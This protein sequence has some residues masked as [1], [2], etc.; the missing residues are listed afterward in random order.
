MNGVAALRRIFGGVAVWLFMAAASATAG[1]WTGWRGPRGDG[2]CDEPDAPERWSA[3]EQVRWKAD[4]PGKGVSSPIIAGDRVFLTA[5][6]GPRH[7]QLHVLCLDARDGHLLWHRRFWGTA[8]TLRHEQKSS[9]ATPTPVTDGNRVW[10]L[11][12]SGDVFCLETSGDLVWCRSLAQ[13]YEPFQNRFGAGSSPVLVGDLLILQCDHWGQS[14]ML[15][16]DRATGK[17]A[18]KTDR[19]EHIAWSSPLVLEVDGAPQLVMSATFQVKG[20]DA[21][22]GRQIWAAGGLTR[23]CIPTPV[24]ADGLIFAVSGPKGETLALRAGGRGDITE[25][26]VVWRSTRAAPFVPSPL[27]VGGLYYVVD[28]R[29]IACC[30]DA[31][32]GERVWQNRLGGAFTASPVA[33]GRLLYF[34]DEE[35]TTTVLEAGRAFRVL[36]K[37]RLDEPVFASPAIARG[38]LFIRTDQH[39]FCIAGAA[40][41]AGGTPGANR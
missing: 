39:L 1:D 37:N 25:S 40:A 15:A 17:N 11:F 14:Y 5:S 10:A 41:S 34:M 22:T 23:E 9:M 30:F 2:T 29:G 31:Q 35:G 36:S 28:D 3:T 16:I 26:H 6:D 7:D 24:A 8:P 13:E 12:G 20:Y 4:L 38:D 33:A 21:R 19:S 27:V 18:W 32:S